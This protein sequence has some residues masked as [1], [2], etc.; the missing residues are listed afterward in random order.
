MIIK[1]NKTIVDKRELLNIKI[2]DKL[3]QWLFGLILNCV[4]IQILHKDDTPPRK[5]QLS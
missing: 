4:N 5:V 1:D 3:R 2:K